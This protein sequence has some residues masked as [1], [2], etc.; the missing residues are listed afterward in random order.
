MKPRRRRKMDERT[1]SLSQL[2]NRLSSWSEQQEFQQNLLSRFLLQTGVDSLS[3]SEMSLSDKVQ[4]VG[5]KSE[6]VCQSTNP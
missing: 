5:E 3:L 1:L 6:R 2:E 4:K